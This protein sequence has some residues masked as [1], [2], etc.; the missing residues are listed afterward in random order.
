M[1]NTKQKAKLVCSVTGQERQSSHK[2]I[3]KKAE[4]HGVDSEEWRKYYVSK[5]ALLEL[6]AELKTKTISE[7]LENSP[8]TGQD[9]EKILKY[10]GKSKKTLDDYKAAK[11]VA[12]HNTPAEP[13]ETQEEVAVAS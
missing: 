7:F 12:K 9:I 13:A 4:H 5:P 2:Y 1:E 6:Q 3:A 8:F 11:Y 10:N